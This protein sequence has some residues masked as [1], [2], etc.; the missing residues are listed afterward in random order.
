MEYQRTYSQLLKNEAQLKELSSTVNSLSQATAQDISKAAIASV[1]GQIKYKQT[2]LTR[3]TIQKDKQ[4]NEIIEIT[5]LSND[6]QLIFSYITALNKSCSPLTFE[7]NRI[8]PYLARSVA[9][10]DTLLQ[11]TATYR[12]DK[13]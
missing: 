12:Q 11:F 3:L 1:L 6:E 4:K 7:I 10:T 13:R 5:G 8:N 9:S 2:Y